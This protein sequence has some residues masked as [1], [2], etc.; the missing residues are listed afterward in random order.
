MAIA[1]LSGNFLLKEGKLPQEKLWK[2]FLL[3]SW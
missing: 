1:I 2:V 3:L